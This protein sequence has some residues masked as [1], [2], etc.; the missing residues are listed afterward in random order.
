MN[1]AGKDAFLSL[2]HGTQ[3][4]STS[5]GLGKE[6]GNFPSR[7]L[8]IATEDYWLGDQDDLYVFSE[9]CFTK[10]GEAVPTRNGLRVDDHHADLGMRSQL[11]RCATGPRDSIRE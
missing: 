6:V 9:A 4:G 8:R 11:R 10:F 3:K 1:R 5:D 7:R 2:D